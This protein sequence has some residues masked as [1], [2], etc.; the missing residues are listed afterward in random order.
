MQFLYFNCKIKFDLKKNIEAN[1]VAMRVSLVI[2][3]ISINSFR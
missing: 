3:S 1:S 2:S